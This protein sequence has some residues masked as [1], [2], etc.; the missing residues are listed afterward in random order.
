MLDTGMNVIAFINQ[1]VKASNGNNCH[2]NCAK[3]HNRLAKILSYVAASSFTVSKSTAR[4]NHLLRV[5]N[6]LLLLLQ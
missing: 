3:V 2:R 5:F 6:S 4:V 1:G